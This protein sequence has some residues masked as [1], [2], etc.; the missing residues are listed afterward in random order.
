VADQMYG[1]YGDQYYASIA[2]DTMAMN[3]NDMITLGVPPISVAMHVAA[4]HSSW[5]K[6][7]V[8]AQHLIDGWK[9]A[10]DLAECA[11]AG[12]ES[13]TLRDMVEPNTVVLSGSA[14]GLL[15]DKPRVFSPDKIR[16]GDAIVILESTGIHAN[17]LTMVRDIG[18]VTG[19]DARVPNG[20]SFGEALLDPTPIYVP[21]VKRCIESGA[22][23][24]YAAN[25]TGHGWRKLMRAPQPFA[26]HIDTIPTPQPVFDFIQTEGNI[27]DREMYGNYNMGAGF[28]LYVPESD[29][30]KLW[31]VFHHF[32]PWT[33]GII[34]AGRVVA[35]DEK[36]VVIKP[37]GITFTA[38]ELKVR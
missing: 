19:Y 1:K 23:I 21:F 26:Y 13:P 20:R 11:Y 29:V 37:K 30:K 36:K 25:V 31:D 28:A 9:A 7:K 32:A 12:G 5:F 18:G 17:G 2:Q 35:S 3:V 16:D 27:D 24:H 38:D 22:D 6:D 34:W 14:V 10:C 8:R 4:G 33:F 15:R